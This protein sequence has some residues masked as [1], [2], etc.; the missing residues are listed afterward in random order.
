MKRTLYL[1]LLA[2][3]V[4]FGILGFLTI[5]TFTTRHTYRY[6]Q[7]QEADSLYREAKSIASGY[8]P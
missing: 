5:S 4:A 2:G 6:L 3:Y 1:K 8:A 7:D